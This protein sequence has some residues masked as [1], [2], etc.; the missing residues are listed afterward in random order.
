MKQYVRSLRPSF[1]ILFLVIL[2][3]LLASYTG[4]AA[5]FTIAD[6]DAAALIAALEEA[7][8]GDVV[9]L[10]ANGTYLLTQ[11]HH[12][13]DGPNGLP[14]I[15]RTIRIEGNGATIRR[16][17]DGPAFRIFY[18]IGAG[19]GTE[20]IN[21]TVENGFAGE[22]DGGGMFNRNSHPTITDCLFRKNQGRN[23]GGIFN[24]GSAPKIRCSVFEANIAGTGDGTIEGTG[25]G[26]GIYNFNSPATIDHCTFR[27]NSS[28]DGDGGG[29]GNWGSNVIVTH[30]RFED[31]N[32]ATGGGGM[33]NANG[34][35]P[36]V[37]DCV[38]ENNVSRWDGGGMV[39]WPG[40]D[41][42]VTN[43]VFE[44]NSSREFGGGMAN[45]GSS[46]TVTGCVFRNNLAQEAG[47][48]M[49]SLDE[50][51]PSVTST[52]FCGNT[53]DQVYGSWQDHG[54][55]QISEQCNG[56][57]QT[58]YEGWMRNHFDEADWDDPAMSGPLANPAGDGI[59][60]LLKYALGL[61]PARTYARA[62][63]PPEIRVFPDPGG[64]RFLTLSFSHPSERSDI[65]YQVQLS[66]D[67]NAWSESAVLVATEDDGST[68]TRTYR[69]PA[70]I[71]A[72]DRRFV[73]LT[74]ALPS[75]AA[76]APPGD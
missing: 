41:A 2:P 74:V 18:L 69:D 6:G 46:P 66:S 3:W 63:P 39:N 73:R 8:D 25:D 37:A 56:S 70:P 48:G 43:T 13:A 22:Y 7:T 11:T 31:N 29:I 15:S 14:A 30:S 38:F 9:Q 33:S 68:T 1:W 44:G 72:S 28:W 51:K 62:V 5:T 35:S 76:S 32:S 26:G 12:I 24:T 75:I 16:A 53:P 61:D 59:D 21:L 57:G 58:S 23:G 64:E 52:V 55:N 50:G 4:R 10:A 20:L 19:P 47:G 36:T 27:K 71:D 17:P 65:D 42:T 67:L 34:S 49:A 45:S 60:N 40:A 54:S